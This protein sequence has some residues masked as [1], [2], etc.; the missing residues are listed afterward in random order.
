MLINYQ[1]MYAKFSHPV[2]INQHNNQDKFVS[3]GKKENTNGNK[4]IKENFNL[5]E[6]ILGNK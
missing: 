3:I 5:C 6:T 2:N 4:I 1:S